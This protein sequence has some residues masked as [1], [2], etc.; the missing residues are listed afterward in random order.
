MTKA[1]ARPANMDKLEDE[2]DRRLAGG[3]DVLVG[4]V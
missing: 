2:E 1:L 4:F 3:H